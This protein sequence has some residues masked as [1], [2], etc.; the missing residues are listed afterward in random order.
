MLWIIK[1]KLKYKSKNVIVKLNKVFIQPHLEYCVQFQSLSLAGEK[2][3]IESVERCALKL[4]NGYK[5]ISYVDRLSYS[6]LISLDKSCLRGDLIE[7]FKMSKDIEIL[8]NM[9]KLN[10][11]NC[12]RGNKFKVHKE[13]C[14]L[15]VRKYFFNQR[16][17]DVWNSLPNNVVCC[18]TLTEFKNSLD[19]I[20]YY[21]E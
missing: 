21:N 7:M 17:V 6:N 20:N 19:K 18:N 5:N 4:I 15:N 2:K 12:L 14:K 13:R 3:M 9:F 16:I 10:N 1:R 11:L 8:N